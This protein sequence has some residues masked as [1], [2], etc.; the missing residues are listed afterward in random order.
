MTRK[1]RTEIE[2]ILIDSSARVNP[3]D[4]ETDTDSNLLDMLISLTQWLTKEVE[5]LNE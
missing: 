3:K 1:Q 4:I 5:R 2:E